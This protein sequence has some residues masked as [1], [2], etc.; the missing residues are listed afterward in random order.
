VAQLGPRQRQLSAQ[1]EIQPH[2]VPI[3]FVQDVERGVIQRAQLS[4]DCAPLLS[5]GGPLPVG[6]G[7]L[8]AQRA[9]ALV[10]AGAP[11]LIRA[12]RYELAPA[13]QRHR[14]PAGRQGSASMDEGRALL[15]ATEKQD[16][17]PFRAFN[18]THATMTRFRS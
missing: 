3:E 17:R 18:S 6:W 2:Q 10:A 8:P 12:G 1:P 11:G 4:A 14:G 13:H 7:S 9:A 5:G 15:Q 16:R